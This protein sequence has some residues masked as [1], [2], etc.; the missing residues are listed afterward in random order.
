M[1]SLEAVIYNECR[2]VDV[3]VRGGSRLRICL[4]NIATRAV[5]L[6]LSLLDDVL[7]LRL[8]LLL[9][10][11]E[12]SAKWT[13][14]D[15]VAKFLVLLLVRCLLLSKATW[16]FLF[17]MNRPC[18]SNLRVVERLHATLFVIDQFLVFVKK[19][20]LKFIVCGRVCAW[21]IPA[22]TSRKWMSLHQLLRWSR[23]QRRRI[24]VYARAC[25]FRRYRTSSSI[26]VR[27]LTWK[28]IWDANVVEGRI[29]GQLVMIQFHVTQLWWF[30]KFVHFVW[31][32]V[33]FAVGAQARVCRIWPN[34]VKHRHIVLSILGPWSFAML[35]EHFLL[36]ASRKGSTIFLAFANMRRFRVFFLMP[37]KVLQRLQ[38]SGGFKIGCSTFS[39]PRNWLLQDTFGFF[40]RQAGVVEPLCV[41]IWCHL[42]DARFRISAQG[43]LVRD[44]RSLMTRN[45]DRGG[46]WRSPTR[47]LL[48]S[49]G[50]E[51]AFRTF[52]SIL[53]LHVLKLFRIS[54]FEEPIV[55]ITFLFA[56]SVGRIL[57]HRRHRSLT[58]LIAVV[59]K[60][61]L[62]LAFF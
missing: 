62:I 46:P 15:W 23:H 30:P 42:F 34:F 49:W 47:I 20:L 52:G 29:V 2:L 59:L 60:N 54:H 39:L 5:T 12:M 10:L 58:L 16:H 57:S 1:I 45:S 35:R 51:A 22:W 7:M 27:L 43:A 53:M 11:S 50:S 55:R 31:R 40:V 36:D 33:K 56:A 9:L 3:K 28:R 24:V 21:A 26:L 19:A 13:L 61:V 38:M 4:Q 8:L 48:V 37:A 17:P 44:C 14:L 25:K 18:F 32:T 6:K 41:G